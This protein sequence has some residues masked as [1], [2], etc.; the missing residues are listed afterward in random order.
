MNYDAALYQ[1]DV[2]ISYSSKQTREAYLVRDVLTANGISSWMAP[3]CIPAASDYTT[4]IPRAIEGCKIMVLILSSQAQTSDWVP[5]EVQTAIVKGKM[6][7]PFAI[8][9]C[10]MEEAF[11]FLISRYQRIN[12]YK[13]LSNALEELV[14]SIYHLKGTEQAQPPQTY[15]LK[16]RLRLYRRRRIAAIIGAIVLAVGLFAGMSVVLNNIVMSSRDDISVVSGAV[17]ECEWNYDEDSKTLTISGDGSAASGLISVSPW[18]SYMTEVKTLVVEDGVTE[19]CDAAMSGASTLTEVHLPDSLVKIGALAFDSCSALKE[20]QLPQNL[21]EIGMSAFGNCGSLTK[22]HIPASVSTIGA[23]A[24]NM[25]G[26]K[27]VEVEEDNAAFSSADGCLF[28]K[29]KTKLI[30]YPSQK[31]DKSYTIPDT[32]TDIEASA[33]TGCRALSSVQFSEHITHIGEGAFS[34]CNSLKELTLPDSLV[35][36]GKEAFYVCS[37]VKTVHMGNNVKQISESA[38]A[39]CTELT[40]VTLSSQLSGIPSEMFEYCSKLTSV[41]IPDGVSYIEARAFGS[42]SSLEKIQIPDSVAKIDEHALDG[43]TQICIIGSLGSTAES[44][45]KEN[46]LNFEEKK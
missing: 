30:F 42:C 14:I 38:F 34:G 25:S 23:R 2:F 11:D 10:K 43:C 22:I 32:V 29:K 40:E 45:A 41:K 24:F 44:Y 12:A 9:N 17:G 15:Y 3:D 37:S 19:L 35:S 20:I 5:K 16:R 36:I 18:N 13:N 28:N 31:T 26:M 39:Q 8:Q 1:N 21:E 46:Q 4:E 27:T 33:F 7:I 6:I